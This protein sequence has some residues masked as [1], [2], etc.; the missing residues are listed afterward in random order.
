MKSH[1]VPQ[2]SPFTLKVNCKAKMKIHL[3]PMSALNALC[4]QVVGEVSMVEITSNDFSR[5]KKIS[6]L[7]IPLKPTHCLAVH[8]CCPVTGSPQHVAALN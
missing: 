3:C 5:K 1:S 2:K 8:A 6:P 4:N 7:P